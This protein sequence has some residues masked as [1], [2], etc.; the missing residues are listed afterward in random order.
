MRVNFLV[1]LLI[2]TGT[3]STRTATEAERPMKPT[4]TWIL[5]ADGARARIFANHGPGKGIEAVKGAEFSADHRPDHEIVRDR[6]GR[7]FES[8]GATRHAIE[9]RQ[10]PHRELKRS[11]SERL[12]ALLEEELAAKAYDRVVLV[13]PPTTLGDL[14]AAL[15]AA[16]R[17]AV[18][19]E[20]DKDLTKTPVAELPRHLG[21]VL[22]V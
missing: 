6:S 1:R 4:T 2:E 8:V 9:P 18:S 3:A 16:V 17:E 10:D 12:A 14:R 22:A 19:A 20:L 15:P 21:A 11:F 5:I 13:A 7:T